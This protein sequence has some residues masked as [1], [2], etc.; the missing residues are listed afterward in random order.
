MNGQ[1]IGKVGMGYQSINGGKTWNKFYDK[2]GQIAALIKN[3]QG[4]LTVYEVVNSILY[5]SVN[6]GVNWTTVNG[7]WEKCIAVATDTINSQIIYVYALNSTNWYGGKYTS[8]GIY[9]SVNGGETWEMVL[10]AIEVTL[11]AADPNDSSI[12]YA[13]TSHQGVYRSTDGGRHWNTMKNGLPDNKPIYAL[14][15]DPVH[16]NTL[17]V[18]TRSGVFK[19]NDSGL[20]WLNISTGFSKGVDVKV[21]AIDP[22]N[23]KIIYSGV[24]YDGIFKSIDSGVSWNP[25]NEGIPCSE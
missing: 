20:N 23:P 2:T 18:G 1:S 6:N 3:P 21:L 4:A 14:V 15:I 17:Y 22:Q 5:K 25:I 10:P 24:D 13:G 19:S 8:G 7:K 11:L 9:K 16:S 12:I